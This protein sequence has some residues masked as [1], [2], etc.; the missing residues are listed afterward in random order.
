MAAA[1]CGEAYILEKKCDDKWC[2]LKYTYEGNFAFV[3][4]GYNLRSGRRQR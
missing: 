4:I 1:D 2:K 3:L